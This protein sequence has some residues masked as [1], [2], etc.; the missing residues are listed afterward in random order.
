MS[1]HIMRTTKRPIPPVMQHI[2][3]VDVGPISVGIEY[4]LLAD[5]IAQANNYER[6]NDPSTGKPATTVR[7]QGVTL[8]VFEKKGAEL[9]EYLRFD[10]FEGSP[11]YHYIQVSGEYQEILQLDSDA[12]GDPLAWALER[13]RTRLT[14]MLG[15]VGAHDLANRVGQHAME[16]ALPQIAEAAYRARFRTDEE[17]IH[18]GAVN[19]SAN[20]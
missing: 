10:C 4:R 14:P 18:R 8:H 20:P 16:T 5:D 9:A 12:D 15:R 13:L 2:E 17:A 1:S 11:R 6:P 3:F 7:G 19:V